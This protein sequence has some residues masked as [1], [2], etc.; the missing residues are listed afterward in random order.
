MRDA[1]EREQEIFRT[2]H[3][4]DDLRTL[5]E[6][7]ADRDFTP[8]QTANAILGMIELYD[9]RFQ[10]LITDFQETNTQENFE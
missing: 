6:G 7:V 2:W 4:I 1:Y 10:H 9:V 8:D 3:I 5:L